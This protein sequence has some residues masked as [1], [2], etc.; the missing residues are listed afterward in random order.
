M[1]LR[2]DTVTKI[3]KLIIILITI[4]ALAGCTMFN[5]VRGSGLPVE[6]N[7]YLDDFTAVSI[8]ETCDLTITQ[9]DSFSIVITTDDNIADYLEVEES[10][11]D[12][13]IGL[14]SGISYSNIIFEA[15]VTMPELNKLSANGVSKADVS[16]FTSSDTLN[17][18]VN[19]ASEVNMDYVSIAGVNASVEGASYLNFNTENIN[20]SANLECEGAS[21]LVFSATSGSKNANI[22]C[23]GASK[24]DMKGYTANKVTVEIDGASQAWVNLSG[25][26]SGSVAGASV[27]RYRGGTLGSLEQKDASSA[28]SY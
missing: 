16:G 25:T 2:R 1:L 4:T 9:G 24:I 28:S 21:E 27:L 26:L 10:D 5:E 19:G 7:Y 13:T 23:E 3:K 11:G 6:K 20:G 14:R 22:F 8:S 18:S 12:L 15:V 17:I